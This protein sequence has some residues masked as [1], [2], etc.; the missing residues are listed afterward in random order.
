M[1]RGDAERRLR[2]P[3]DVGVE[4]ERPRAVE[5]EL[6]R[7]LHRVGQQEDDPNED[8]PAADRPVQQ[9][10]DEDVE[11]LVAQTR[12]RQQHRLEPAEVVLQPADRVELPG[13]GLGVGPL[14]HGV[15]DDDV[16]EDVRVV[17]EDPVHARVEQPAHVVWLVDRPHV[18]IDAEPL[19]G[20]HETRLGHVDVSVVLRHVEVLGR[21]PPP[22]VQAEALEDVEGAD[23]ALGHRC[24]HLGQPFTERAQ[25]VEV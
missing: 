22:A 11:P 9:R 5:A 19:G 25:V 4:E 21:R 8:E 3:A 16:G 14:R 13:V 20:A 15:L 17:G 18:H 6:E 2:Q 10:E 24:G 1:P 23:L 12:E 7:S